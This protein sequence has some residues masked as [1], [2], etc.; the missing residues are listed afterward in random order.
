MRNTPLHQDHQ[1]IHEP[2][3]HFSLVSDQLLDTSIDHDLFD[4]QSQV[5]EKVI[6][7]HEHV[8]FWN[9]FVQQVLQDFHAMFPFR[10]FFITFEEEDGLSLFI[11][12]MGQ[13]D[14]SIKACVRQALSKKLRGGLKANPTA[15]ITIEEFNVLNQPVQVDM[16]EINMLMVKV[17]DF[18]PNRV[19]L[20]G[21]AYTSAASLSANEEAVI[22][23]ILSVMVMVVGSSKALRHTVAEL[24]YYSSHDPLT[25]LYNRRHFNDMLSYEINRSERHQHQFSIAFIDCD[26][27]KDVNDSFGHPAGDEVLIEIGNIMTQL[28]RKGDQTCRMGGDEFAILLPETDREGA[29]TVAEHIRKMVH[30]KVFTAPSGEKYHATISVGTVTY[31]LDAT[32]IQ[33]LMI[34]CDTALYQAKGAGRNSIMAYDGQISLQKARAERMAI[35]ELRTALQQERIVPYFQPIFDCQGDQLYA[36]E[37]VARMQKENGDIIPAGMFI[38]AIERYGLARDLDRAIIKSTFKAMREH[39]DQGKE[40]GSVFINLSAQEIQGRGILEYAEEQ[41]RVMQIPCEKIVFEL[42]EREAISDM[43]SMRKFLSNL[44]EKGFKFALDDFGSGYNSFHYLRELRF[45]YVKIDGEFVRSIQ[46]SPV[47]KALVTHL[48]RLCQELGIKTVAEY[49]E[50]PEIYAIIKDADVDFAQGYHLGMPNK[51]LPE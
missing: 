12:Y 8:S 42:T 41:S 14:E 5:L 44:Q 51:N 47:D 13:Y 48:S 34:G 18:A 17:P 26:N 28:M 39:M 10:F 49:I 20:L 29:Q 43:G 21:A 40:L 24:E 35:E 27:F 23:S 33:D 19:G 4:R 22:R 37:V 1:F 15:P 2:V 25:G 16:N 6:L 46:S 36:C 9:E 50:N 38:E 32:N 31:P 7:S 3:Q 45:D 11:Y 30:N